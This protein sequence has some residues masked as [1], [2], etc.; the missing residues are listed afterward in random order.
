[1]RKGLGVAT[2]PSQSVIMGLAYWHGHRL[3]S[4]SL[5]PIIFPFSL[6]LSKP[7]SFFSPSHQTHRSAVLGMRQPALSY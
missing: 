1:M 2:E 3:Q 4:P 5:L 7:S 6:S